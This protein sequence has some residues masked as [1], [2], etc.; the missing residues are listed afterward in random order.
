MTQRISQSQTQAVRRQMLAQQ[1]GRCLLC[2]QPIEIGTDVLDHDHD[3]GALRGV[4]HRGCNAMLGHIENNR[5]RH[6]LTDPEKFK[7]WL[8]NVY[9]YIYTDYS[10]RRLHPTHKTAEEKK[11]AAANK[12]KRKL[13]SDRIAAANPEL[14]AALKARDAVMKQARARKNRPKVKGS[15][16]A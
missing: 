8:S 10:A 9:E 2:N 13:A 7:A 4:L 12:R 16:D 6:L 1:G 15:K 5:P 11:V 14:A 3:T